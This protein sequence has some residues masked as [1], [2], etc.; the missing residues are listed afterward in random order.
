MTDLTSISNDDWDV[1]TALRGPDDQ[2]LQI[3]KYF[4]TAVIRSVVGI[5][6]GTWR[7]DITPLDAAAFGLDTPALRG[8]LLTEWRRCTTHFQ[9]HIHRAFNVLAAREDAA[10]NIY[11]K[12]L[13]DA[14]AAR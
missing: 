3:V 11:W 5:P 7:C 9:D 13:Q 6:T 10:V 14:L 1:L 12:R 4:T 8:R 2:S